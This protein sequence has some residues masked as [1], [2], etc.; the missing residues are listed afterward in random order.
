MRAEDWIKVEERLPERKIFNKVEFNVSEWVL[1]CYNRFGDKVVMPGQYHFG[2]K[3]WE[4]KS[5]VHDLSAGYV[6]DSEKVSHW[7]PIILPKEE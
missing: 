5:A 4:V 6:I 1:V 3:R 7:M 2:K